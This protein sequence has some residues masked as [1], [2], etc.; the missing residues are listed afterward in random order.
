MILSV[1]VLSRS[2]FRLDPG[3]SPTAYPVSVSCPSGGP[4][5]TAW[6][7]FEADPPN[8]SISSGRL[9]IIAT[10]SDEELGSTRRGGER[11][12]AT[13][14]LVPCEV[15]TALAQGESFLG[16]HAKRAG[17]NA[18][19]GALRLPRVSVFVDQNRAGPHGHVR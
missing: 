18:D 13:M 4:L 7:W 9:N 11:L 8:V 16:A 15:L 5:I 12:Q 2:P 6:G 14:T 17:A 3:N 10:M 1:T 19:R